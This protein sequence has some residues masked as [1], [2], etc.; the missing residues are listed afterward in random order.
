MW[1]PCQPGAAAQPLAAAEQGGR[2]A[3]GRSFADERARAPLPVPRACRVGKEDRHAMMEGSLPVVGANGDIQVA[4]PRPAGV[5]AAAAASA[6]PSE[7]GAE[8]PTVP[9]Q[10][11]A[12][13]PTAAP[14]RG[15]GGGGRGRGR[16]R[17][18][19]GAGGFGTVGAGALSPE[20]AELLDE[21]DETSY[22]GSR[23]AGIDRAERYRRRCGGAGG[24]GG[25]EGGAAADED[26]P[27]P[28]F[29]DPIT[30]ELVV[31]PAIS[32]H[33]ARALCGLLDAC[34]GALCE[35][36]VRGGGGGVAVWLQGT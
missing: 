27:L 4:P 9:P 30:L 34:G 24:A 23:W 7:A 15:G 21:G 33:G 19:G 28:G 29:L 17:R 14:A 18:G 31:N 12:A 25:G 32:P 1:T 13:P 2:T 10:A 3:S 35:L 6:Q 36:G 22:A 11:A 8:P 5:A 16:G 20:R 26:H